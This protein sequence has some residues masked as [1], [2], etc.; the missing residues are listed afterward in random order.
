MINK[1]LKSKYKVVIGLEVH[2]QLQTE[3]KIFAPDPNQ[4]G[5]EANTNISAIT[6]GHPGVLP[7]LN[8]KAVENAIKLGL[9][10]NCK[11]AEWQHFDRKNYFYPDL[12]KGYQI[13][14]DK[15]PICGPGEYLIKFKDS[16][17]N[18]V[19]KVV[20]IHH[21]H[22]EEDAGKSIHIDGETDTLLDYNRA[23]TPLVEMV[24][25]PCIESG[26]EAAAFM[27]EIRRLVRYL[28][29]CDGNMEEGS[30]RC[31]VNVSVMLH[32]AKEF[33]TKVEIKNM[34]SMRFIQKAVEFEIER[35]ITAVESGEKIIQ[36]TRSFDPATN[37]TSGMRE[38]E[39]MNDYRYF[40]EPDLPPFEVKKDWIDAVK[41][42]MPSLPNELFTKYVNTYQLTDYDANSLIESKE[43]AQY[44]EQICKKTTNFKSASNWLNGPIK[45]YLN[46][47][48]Q[49]IVNFELGAE[50]IAE[51]INLIDSGTISFSAASQKL[52][53]ILV[54]NPSNSVLEIAQNENLIQQSN[55]DSLQTLINE[56][57]IANAEKVKEYKAGKKGL[58]AMFM[59]EVMKKSK[60][61]A[62]P[63]LTS[64]L[65]AETLA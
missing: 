52:F 13:T 16:D 41:S 2:A 32:N 36:E 39:T 40:P 43:I 34:N 30:L 3:S 25:E 45:S 42:M 19:E 5:S 8:K 1:E 46:E 55:S 59:G 26:E 33:G 31:D 65:L 60:G 14:Q 17:G 51:T 9:A 63:K 53:P 22:L 64:K 62:D 11:I 35:Q 21:I 20:K 48:N 29:I 10:C 47:N 58:L 27:T 28:D 18:S 15:T 57:L 6:L 12:P 54:A 24:T 4:F 37:T 38:K 44:F 61:T 23:G 56:V 50:K 7:K 49:E